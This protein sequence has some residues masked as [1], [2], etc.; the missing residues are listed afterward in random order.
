MF[1]HNIHIQTL[2]VI[3]TQLFLN[4]M[5]TSKADTTAMY[6][7]ASIGDD[8]IAIGTA[9]NRGTRWEAYVGPDVIEIEPSERHS[10]GGIWSLVGQP[11]FIL[12]LRN[13]PQNSP[14]SQYLERDIKTRVDVKYDVTKMKSWDAL[15]FVDELSPSRPASVSH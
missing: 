4:K 10:V 8:Y 13:V 2:P 15:I 6:L 9:Y 12:N 3:S 5:I 1:N 7:Q 14:V 11:A